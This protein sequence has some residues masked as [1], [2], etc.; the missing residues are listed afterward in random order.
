[1]GYRGTY[2]HIR[3]KHA[4]FQISHFGRKYLGL[5]EHLDHASQQKGKENA[6]SSNF[7]L[8][9]DLFQVLARIIMC[10]VL[11]ISV[12]QRVAPTLTRSGKEHE[13]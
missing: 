1:V 13:N 3:L 5:L 12:L 9:D 7:D 4:H 11:F 6:T 8:F 2:Q 10:V